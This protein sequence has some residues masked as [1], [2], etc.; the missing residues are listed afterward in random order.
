MT[1]PVISETLS[2]KMQRVDHDTLIRLEGKVDNITATVQNLKD[3]FSP[4]L[5]EINKDISE[6]K[7]DVDALKLW[8]HDFELGYRW[9]VA[10]SSIIGG[11]L[12]F[13]ISL[14]VKIFVK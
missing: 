9:A 12:G 11:V 7:K 4:R 13:L 8:R 14:A 1:E 2:D 10:L 3:D 5:V 6:L